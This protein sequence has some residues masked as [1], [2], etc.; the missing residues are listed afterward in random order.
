MPRALLL[1]AAMSGLLL[2]PASVGLW[3]QVQPPAAAPEVASAASGSINGT[4]LD[5][6]GAFVRGAQVILQRDGAPLQ[7]TT[8]NDDG[9]YSFA[10]VPAGD[11]Q[12]SITAS[13]FSPL[14]T[15]ATVQAG[16]TFY[17]PVVTMK[18]A[19]NVTQVQVAMTQE[20]IAEE[21]IKEQEK[22]RVLGFI[23]NYYVTYV[24]DAVPLSSKQKFKLALRSNIDP[25]NF[26]IVGMIAGIQQG[27]NHFHEYGQGFEGYA[28]RYGA[29]YA[30]NVTST[31]IGGALLPSVLKQDPRYFYKGKGSTRSRALY[32]VGMS[33][34]CKGD[35]GHWQ[36][37]YSAI[38]GS[39]AAGGLSNLY[40]P[41]DDRSS[42]A[43]TFENA[44]VSI[45]ATAAANLF[46]E[47][48]VRKLTP[49]L[50]NHDPAKAKTPKPQTPDDTGL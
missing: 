35:N 11:F 20:Q 40:Y 33:V 5:A 25:Y 8:S 39:L 29:N 7:H 24:A 46:Q 36:A 30:D 49:G 6:D 27:Q 38:L 4:V 18:V 42:A 48:L 31:F 26:L 47:F 16:Q 37:N 43:L 13:G 9:Q 45:G 50:R 1:A 2:A 14:M 34:I 22:Q 15:A 17:A 32:A 21:Q 41:S 10:D 44:A 23:P 19:A 12:L 3:A 28:K